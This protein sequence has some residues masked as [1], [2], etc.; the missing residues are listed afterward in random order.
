MRV[1]LRRPSTPLTISCLAQLRS[2]LNEARTFSSGSTSPPQHYIATHQRV[3]SGVSG[4]SAG[5]SPTGSSPNGSSSIVS[6]T[7][8]MVNGV[9]MESPVSQLRGSSGSPEMLQSAGSRGNDPVM[10]DVLFSGWDP[11]LPDPEVLNH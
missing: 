4:G 9:S 5:R 2:Q 8:E 11:D 1:P 10:M 7:M 3:G 6:P